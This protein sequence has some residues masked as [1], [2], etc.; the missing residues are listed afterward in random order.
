MYVKLM[1][2]PSLDRD[3]PILCSDLFYFPVDLYT[4]QA[5]LDAEVLSLELMKMK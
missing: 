4:H 1:D 2:A 3:F 5:R